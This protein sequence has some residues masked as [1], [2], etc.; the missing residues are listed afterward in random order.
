M[1]YDQNPLEQKSAELKNELVGLFA[2]LFGVYIVGSLMAL[3]MGIAGHHW[4]ES[5]ARL[6]YIFPAYHLGYWLAQPIGG[7]TDK[8]DE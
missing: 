4:P 5:R 1:H 8:G 7:E 6:T 2:S 3:C